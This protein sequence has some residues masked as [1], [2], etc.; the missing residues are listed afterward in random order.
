M[1]MPEKLIELDRKA[2]KDL[3][4]VFDSFEEISYINSQRVLDNFK[5]NRV[6]ESL[7]AGSTG[8]G[9]GD[10]GRDALDNIFAGVFESEAAFARHNIVNGTQAISIALFGV[11]RPG[12]VM[13]SITGSPYD[14]LSE[15][16]GNKTKNGDGSLADFGVDYDEVP[17]KDGKVDYEAVKNTVSKYGK[18][19]KM[20]YIQRSKGYE[21]RP[22]FSAEEI[23]EIVDFCHGI[24]DAC[25][26]VDNCYG[27]FCDE[28]EPTYYGADLMAGS[29]I[30]NPGG[31]I[32]KTGGYV[33]GKKRYV[34]LASYRLTTVG[35]GLEC[36]ATLD[37]KR[38][39]YRG[40]FLAPHV[41]CQ[42]KKTAA[43]AAY[44][45]NG[46]G[47]ESYPSYKE[48]RHDIIQ[49]VIL[50]S[51]EKLCSF[52]QG[53]QSA[54]PVDSYVT[55]EPWDMPGYADKVIMAAGTF[56]SG[57]SIELSADGPLREPYI[58]YFQGGLTYESGRAAILAAAEKML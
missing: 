21:N 42:A 3:R 22:T 37:E 34:E 38:D 56:I 47:F 17:M 14:T 54:S 9:Y 43:F 10:A 36:G 13:I 30:K 46:L 41:V 27:E 40:F 24:S 18:R 44:I 12:D 16:I 7:F 50:G 33:A 6:S 45:F 19:V 35:I 39:M 48:S 15:V 5:K 20:L 11:L 32:A 2:Q 29:L 4:E 49:T 8:Y 31:G 1:A 57:A 52:C 53:I 55:P 25:V 26:F 28:H 23:G 51:A 58:A